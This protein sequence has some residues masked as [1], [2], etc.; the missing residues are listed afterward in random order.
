MSGVTASPRNRFLKAAYVS[1]GLLA[2]V[3]GLYIAMQIHLWAIDA[4]GDVVGGGMFLLAMW[5]GLP[6]IAL[7]WCAVYFSVKSSDAALAWLVILFAGFVLTLFIPATPSV[8]TAVGA[9]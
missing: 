5:L 8:P 2:L 7:A 1:H 4:P 3:V 9:T 6:G